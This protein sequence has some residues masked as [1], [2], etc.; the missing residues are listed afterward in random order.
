MKAKHAVARTREQAEDLAWRPWERIGAGEVDKGLA[1]LDDRGTW[2]EMATRTEQPM[3]RMKALLAEI[4]SLFPMRFAVVGSI[5]EDTRVALMVES[6]A[7]L[8]DGGRYNNAY[9]FITTLHPVDDLIIAV[10][11][12]VDTLHASQTLV[13]A[14]LAAAAQGQGSSTMRDLLAGVGAPGDDVHG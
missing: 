3:A 4:F 11:E 6:F 5:V 14:V 13:P 8:P 2:W 1:V 7:D 10:R 9:T 12:Y